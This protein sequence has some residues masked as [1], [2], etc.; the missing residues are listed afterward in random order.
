MRYRYNLN[1]HNKISCDL[2]A[3]L[4]S[5]HNVPADILEMKYFVYI[6]GVYWVQYLLRF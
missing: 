4:Y 6:N 3:P 1:A 5:I 2:N